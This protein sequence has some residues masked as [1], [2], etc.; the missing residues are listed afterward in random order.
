M[1]SHA[2]RHPLAFGLIASSTA[3]GIAG[4]DLVLPAVPGLPNVLGGTIEGAQLVV[5]A[6]TAGA[7]LGLLAFGEL[8]AR[9]DQRHLLVASL[10]AYAVISLLC[11]ISPNLHVLVGLRFFQGAAGAAPAVF[12]PGML[13]HLY[14]DERAV[15]AI[16]FLGSIE[17]LAPALAP[18]L[19]LWLITWGGWQ[20][21]FEAIGV[22]AAGL[23]VAL[24]LMHRVLPEVVGRRSSGGYGRLL[25]EAPFLRQALSHALTLGA[26]LIIVCGAPT[27]FVVSMGGTMGD[28][29][30]MQV[31][32]VATFAIAANLAGR[33]ASMYGAET[34]IRRGTL[35]A[36]A[37]TLVILGYALLRGSDIRIVI[38]L[39]VMLNCGFGLR[40]PPGFHAAIVAAKDDARGAALIVVSILLAAALG[41]SV[42]A[43]FIGQGLVAISS[44][45]AAFAC[46]AVATLR[47]VPGSGTQT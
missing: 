8:G 42:V 39:F 5:A 22:L 19:G 33:L 32:G 23:A 17:A 47:L 14:G 13:R 40:G 45:A 34:M 43:P 27:V 12:A 16:G 31:I 37:T 35:L 6:F 29:I 4:T 28:F 26:L 2:P 25:G 20:S 46:A 10:L 36:A 9:F 3:L 15:G 44:G 11:S 21:S 7:A 38:A 24:L 18:I 41:T 1:T 30:L